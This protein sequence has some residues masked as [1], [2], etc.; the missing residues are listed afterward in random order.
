MCTWCSVPDD[1]FGVL[2]L[3]V[4]LVSQVRFSVAE[5]SLQRDIELRVC[6]L[7]HEQWLG[8]RQSAR[9]GDLMQW[10]LLATSGWIAGTW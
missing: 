9:S 10:H 1:H 6:M 2:A 8:R 3:E 7:P 5:N 4:G